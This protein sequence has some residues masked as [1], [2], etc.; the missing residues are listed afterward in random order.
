MDLFMLGFTVV[1]MIL[2]LGGGIY[3]LFKI[4]RHLSVRS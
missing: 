4:S 3:A 1:F 2:T